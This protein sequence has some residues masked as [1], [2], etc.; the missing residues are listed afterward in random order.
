MAAFDGCRY[1]RGPPDQAGGVEKIS[2]SSEISASTSSSSAA[3][4]AT[5]ARKVRVNIFLAVPR[6]LADLS[7]PA[8]F[9]R[10]ASASWLGGSAPSI[11]GRSMRASKLPQDRKSDV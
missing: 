2:H 3:Y 4:S 9:H 8:S 10:S 6:A 1:G 11:S 5:T 7:A